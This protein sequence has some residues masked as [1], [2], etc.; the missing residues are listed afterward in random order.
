MSGDQ[1]DVD[2]HLT[3]RWEKPARRVRPSVVLSGCR[4]LELAVAV[5]VGTGRI[6]LATSTG[7]EGDD[8]VRLWDPATGEP[9]AEPLLDHG[10]WIRAMHALPVAEGIARLVTAH[11][12]D[13]EDTAIYI[14]DAGTGAKVAGPLAGPCYPT[15]MAVVLLPDQRGVLAVIEP[16]RDEVRLWDSAGRYAGELHVPAEAGNLDALVAVALAD[17]RSLLATAHCDEERAAVWLWDVVTSE[18]VS[19]FVHNLDEDDHFYY[20][21]PAVTAE[22]L[23]DG[24]TVLSLTSADD[25][26]TDPPEVHWDVAT[27]AV[28]EDRPFGPRL[29]TVAAMP[30]AVASVP[31]PDGPTLQ[32]SQMP[33]G[34]IWLWDPQQAASASGA[35]PERAP[36]PEQDGEV[37]LVT[38]LPA[39]RDRELFA[40]AWHGD[41]RLWDL[42]TGETVSH[43]AADPE[44]GITAMTAMTL[45]DGRTAVATGHRNGALRLWDIAT[46]TL[47]ASTEP[48]RTGSARTMTPILLPDGRNLLAIG[49]GDGV[50]R[51]RDPETMAATDYL[52][53]KADRP[54][55]AL[56]AVPMP[57]QRVLLASSETTPIRGGTK[58]VR[59]W[60]PA[61]GR[62]EGEPFEHHTYV[63]SLTPIPT[64]QGRTFLA[65]GNSDNTICVWD[66]A[67]RRLIGEI[68]Q[69]PMTALTS[70]AGRVV[71]AT[72]GPGEVRLWDPT[73]CDSLGSYRLNRAIRSL[74]GSGSCLVVG[75]LD[76]VVVLDLVD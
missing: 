9:V 44:S 63:F 25:N 36:E 26:Y 53:N 56:A 70:P 40:S 2:P 62:P 4:E 5:P 14:W 76:G 61:T 28:L 75:C 10:G 47:I 64:A 20:A 13:D 41:V 51:L 1:H 11:C 71:L 58:A 43:I 57:D 69:T 17:G 34:E 6:V 49:D 8:V 29:A 35:E 15:D 48:G 22:L 33:D 21:W 55:W 65:V 24:R 67:A 27:G 16:D 7:C 32:V 59:L 74:T 39:T 12:Y 60:D 50:I 52:F 68:D 54:L 3:L 42:Q 66:V 30:P 38:V 31:L 45:A 18:P 46:G 37:G 23:P 72:T 19:Q 73:T